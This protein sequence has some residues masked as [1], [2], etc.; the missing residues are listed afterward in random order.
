MSRV[1]QRYNHSGVYYAWFRTGARVRIE[2]NGP[3]EEAFAARLVKLFETEFDF[4]GL[5]S[6]S[7]V[8]APL[9]YVFYHRST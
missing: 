1:V 7:R 6:S 9:F 3:N 5:D 4:P 2:V 8:D